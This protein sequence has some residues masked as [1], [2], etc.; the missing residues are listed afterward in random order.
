MLV[1][2]LISLLLWIRI[3]Q[4]QSPGLL[5]WPYSRRQLSNPLVAFAIIR[6]SIL[7]NV[8]VSSSFGSMIDSVACGESFL[9]SP[10]GTKKIGR[11][12]PMLF[13]QARPLSSFLSH[14]RANRSLTFM[15]IFLSTKSLQSGEAN[16]PVQVS[17]VAS[18]HRSWSD[19]R[20]GWSDAKISLR[21]SVHH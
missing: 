2:F 6:R 12:N 13:A 21:W 20:G 1:G 16:R 17:M 5:P 9:H 11:S 4:S 15:V 10:S 19:G 14:V 8:S 7:S 18:R 3:C